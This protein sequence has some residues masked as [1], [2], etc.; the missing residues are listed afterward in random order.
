MPSIDFE[1]QAMSQIVPA[2][3][4]EV[5]N[6]MM[7]ELVPAN[8]SNLI[9]LSFLNEAEGNVYP[10]EAELLGAIKDARAQK[11]EA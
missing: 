2:M 1:Y 10:T 6:Q 4:V 9:V 7:A 5:A 8:D 11:I 3:P